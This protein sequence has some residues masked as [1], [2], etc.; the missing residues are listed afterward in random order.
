LEQ[1][2]THL[3]QE[4][5]TTPAWLQ[6]WQGERIANPALTTL[7]LDELAVIDEIKDVKWRARDVLTEPSGRTGA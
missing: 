2:L 3:Q 6:N 5:A 4:I 1:L 7:A